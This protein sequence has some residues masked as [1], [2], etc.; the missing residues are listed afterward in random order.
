MPTKYFRKELCSNQFFVSGQRVQ[1][2]CF[3]SNVGII[4]L[5]EEK[6]AELIKALSEAASKRKGGIVVIDEPTYEDTKKNRGGSRVSAAFRKGTALRALRPSN[7]FK[8]K[9]AAVATN[10][11][12]EVAPVE[13]ETQAPVIPENRSPADPRKRIPVVRIKTAK[14]GKKTQPTPVEQPGE[15]A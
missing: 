8:D 6:D 3:P 5:D 10:G 15:A 12:G 2:E 14:L 9:K 11:E 1:F 7:P 13:A 4:A